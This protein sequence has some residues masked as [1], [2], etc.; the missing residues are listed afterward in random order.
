MIIDVG[1]ERIVL[2]LVDED[3]ADRALE[4][5][6]QVGGVGAGDIGGGGARRA[7]A[8]RQGGRRGDDDLGRVRD[9]GR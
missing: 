2:H 7:R 4:I 1:L 3:A 6:G 9:R 8:I 5:V